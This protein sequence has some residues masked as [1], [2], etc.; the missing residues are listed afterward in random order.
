MIASTALN[1]A[2]NSG[3]AS[4]RTS[5]K[6]IRCEC[7]KIVF[8]LILLDVLTESL[9]GTKRLSLKVY[10]SLAHDLDLAILQRVLPSARSDRND[11]DRDN[12]DSTNARV[13][14]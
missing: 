11:D 13:M 8:H 2:L 14:R 12:N 4:R 10:R 3:Q 6:G 1:V 9:K 5:D 7:C